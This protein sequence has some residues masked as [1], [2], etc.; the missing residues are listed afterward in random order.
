MYMVKKYQKKEKVLGHLQ[1]CKYFV[2]LNLSE[3]CGHELHGAEYYSVT[4]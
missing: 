3:Y 1:G 4:K 2:I